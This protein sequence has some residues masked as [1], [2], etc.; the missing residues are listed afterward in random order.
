[1]GFGF[2][3]FIK[4]KNRPAKKLPGDDLSGLKEKDYQTLPNKSKS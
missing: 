3:L 1:M 2:L 4:N